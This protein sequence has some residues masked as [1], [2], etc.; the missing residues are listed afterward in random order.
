MKD[1]PAL[2]KRLRALEILPA[3]SQDSEV[4][5][6][7]SLR[8]DGEVLVSRSPL[9]SLYVTGTMQLITENVGKSKSQ[10]RWALTAE[11][12]RNAVASGFKLVDILKTIE[13]MTGTSLSPQWDKKLKAWGKYYGDSHTAQVRLIRLESKQA[14]H[15]LRSADPKLKRWL[16]PLPQSE[17]LAVVKEVNWE[18]TLALLVSYGIHVREEAWW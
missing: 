6:V 9:P 17:A 8:W 10:F 7:N 1:S 12:I 16:Q 4:D 5:L 15:E 14:L 13:T 18:E 11:S 3:H 2:E